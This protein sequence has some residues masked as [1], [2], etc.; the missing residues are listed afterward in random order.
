MVVDD[1]R[2]A[3]WD[4]ESR[5]IIAETKVALEEHVRPFIS[6]ACTHVKGHGGMKR[7]I[8]DVQRHLPDYP[9]VARFDVASYYDTISHEILLHQL[10]ES[11]CPSPLMGAVYLSPLDAAFDAMGDAI[12]Y[13]RYMDDFVILAR[14]RRQLRWAIKKVHHILAGL[15]QT[16]HKKKRFIGR[17]TAG[18][19][20][21]G[22]RLHPNR[23]L[24][25]SA[26]SI[27]RL[28]IHA[29]R[30]YERGASHDR[31]WRYV[32]RWCSWLWGGVYGR[33][34]RK[35][36]VRKYCVLVAKE[37]GMDESVPMYIGL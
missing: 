29:R 30:L 25:P 9:F 22:Y 26:E 12:L 2:I 8:R 37:L 15:K 28:K 32:V 23:R 18:F 34:S 20:F 10:A 4:E 21:L 7:C 1:R 14:T 35:G 27:T 33:V 11:G 24:R 17:T 5:R 19:D 3:L 16:V 13:R 36:G 6:R 31:L